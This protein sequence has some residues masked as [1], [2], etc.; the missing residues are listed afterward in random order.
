[1]SY[2]QPRKFKFPRLLLFGSR[3][4]VATELALADRYSSRLTAGWGIAAALSFLFFWAFG[5]QLWG[6][7]IGVILLDLGM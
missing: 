5:Y 1:M 3:R 4:K 2:R 7:V 6:L